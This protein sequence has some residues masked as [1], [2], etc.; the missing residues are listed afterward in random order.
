MFSYIDLLRRFFLAISGLW[1]NQAKSRKFTYT[2]S[3][4]FIT[5]VGFK[6]VYLNEV[7]YIPVLSDY[8]DFVNLM[9]Q[10][11]WSVQWRLPSQEA[12]ISFD[13]YVANKVQCSC[14]SWVCSTQSASSA[15]VGLGM[16]L[17]PRGKLQ[18]PKGFGVVVCYSVGP[19]FH[20]HHWGKK[21]KQ[22]EG[23][24]CPLKNKKEPSVR[25]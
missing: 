3:L 18:K 22:G 25:E 19:R 8:L 7:F 4:Q 9:S 20:P 14:R 1:K 6:E 21:K 10:K 23:G 24:P 13:I 15:I 11:E 2:S 16:K 12:S 17:R 5:I